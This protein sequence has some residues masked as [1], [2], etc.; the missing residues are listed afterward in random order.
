MRKPGLLKIGYFR[1]DKNPLSTRAKG[2]T[3]Q[4][5]NYENKTTPLLAF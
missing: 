5:L 2:A 4:N 1:I 3:N